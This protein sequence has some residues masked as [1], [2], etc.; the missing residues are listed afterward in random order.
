MFTLSKNKQVDEYAIDHSQEILS[1]F[2]NLAINRFKWEN[3]PIGLE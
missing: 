3:L 2:L 1:R